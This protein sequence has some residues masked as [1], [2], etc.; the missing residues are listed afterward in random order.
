MVGRDSFDAWLDAVYAGESL[1]VLAD[2][3]PLERGKTPRGDE[4]PRDSHGGLMTALQSLSGNCKLVWVARGGAE[5]PSR[6]WSIG[7]IGRT[8][9]PPDLERAF[10]TCR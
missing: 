4:V 2:R 9:H 10:D 1:V 3:D 6:A 7:A 5:A 8:C